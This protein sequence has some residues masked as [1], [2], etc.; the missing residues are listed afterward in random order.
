LGHTFG[1]AIETGMGYGVWLHGEAVAVG[2]IMAAELS[3]ELG[4]LTAVDVQRIKELFLRARLP[5][6]APTQLGADKLLSLMAVDKKVVAGKLRLV[7]LKQIGEA[8]VTGELSQG[9]ILETIER[10]LGAG[11]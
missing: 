6:K 3:V 9:Q 4:W 8:V 10:H 7:L 1:H 5:V 11:K 2:T